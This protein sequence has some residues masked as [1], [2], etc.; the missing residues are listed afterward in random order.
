MAEFNNNPTEFVDF[1]DLF[2][3]LNEKVGLTYEQ[4][5]KAIENINFVKANLGVSDVERGNVNISIVEDDALVG[6]DIT[7][8]EVVVE[9][10][11]IQRTVIYIDFDLKVPSG[12]V[13]SVNGKTGAVELTA[14]DIGAVETVVDRHKVTNTSTET[15]ISYAPEFLT[16]SKEDAYGA[17]IK[18]SRD[19]IY[20]ETAGGSTLDDLGNDLSNPINTLEFT[21]DGQLLING[22]NIEQALTT[23]LE[24]F[25]ERLEPLESSVPALEERVTTLEESGG[26][27]GGGVRVYTA[28]K[29]TL[30]KLLEQ[31]WDNI[32]KVVYTPSTAQQLEKTRVAYSSSSSQSMSTGSAVRLKT[33][34]EYIFYPASMTDDSENEGKTSIYWW[35]LGMIEDYDVRLYLYHTQNFESFAYPKIKGHYVTVKEY[36]GIAETALN[37]GTYKV[38]VR[39]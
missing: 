39:N 30:Y 15:S 3:V 16:Y 35:L 28:T 26:N 21:N 13:K 31:H 9:K 6:L 12:K 17:S 24:A 10:N 27:S 22:S 2:P 33:T 20:M 7:T 1:N 14:T 29:M 18:V 5:R 4:W 25:N 32:E 34:G 23:E 8:R 19:G 37:E 38:Y 36:N 11:G